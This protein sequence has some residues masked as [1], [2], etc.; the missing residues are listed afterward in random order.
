MLVYT[1]QVLE[2]IISQQTLL[3]NIVSLDNEIKFLW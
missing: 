2:G 1:I 3:L